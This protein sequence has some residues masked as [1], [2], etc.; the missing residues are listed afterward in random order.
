MLA[1]LF[2]S[3]FPASLH[4][5]C[6]VSSDWN[7]LPNSQNLS[8]FMPISKFRLHEDFLGSPPTHHFPILYVLPCM[9]HCI[10]PILSLISG[11]NFVSW[12]YSFTLLFWILNDSNCTLFSLHCFKWWFPDLHVLKRKI[13]KKAMHG[14]KKEPLTFYFAN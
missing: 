8:S 5:Y 6:C 7:I 12:F 1:S 3:Y 10:S 4:I 13:N 14:A 9:T 11:L 2:N